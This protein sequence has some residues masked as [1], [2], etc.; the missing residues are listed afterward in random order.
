MKENIHS[1][2]WI[3][4]M[5]SFPTLQSHIGL[6]ICVAQEALAF[7]SCHIAFSQTPDLLATLGS[8]LTL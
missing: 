1:F 2:C 8:F 4:L 7:L 6:P 3:L 5:K